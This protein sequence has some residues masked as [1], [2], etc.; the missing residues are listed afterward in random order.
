[1]PLI[2]KQPTLHERQMIYRIYDALLEHAQ[3]QELLEYIA[4]Y[5]KCSCVMK[6]RVR[7]SLIFI[8]EG[9]CENG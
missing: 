4:G 7:R 3:L 9:R 6:N 2:E 8:F 1:M 5:D